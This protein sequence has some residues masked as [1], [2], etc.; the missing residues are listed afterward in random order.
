M[1]LPLMYSCLCICLASIWDSKCLKRNSLHTIALSQHRPG[2]LHFLWLELKYSCQYIQHIMWPVFCKCFK[3]LFHFIWSLAHNAQEIKDLKMNSKQKRQ[4]QTENKRCSLNFSSNIKS[5]C[6]KH[7]RFIGFLQITILRSC[8]GMIQAMY[9]IEMKNC[10]PL[11]LSIPPTAYRVPTVD[12]LGLV[13]GLCIKVLLSGN[14]WY[15]IASRISFWHS[16]SFL[17]NAWFSRSA[18]ICE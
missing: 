15:F 14:K 11:L 6:I 17:N 16:R 3:S 2:I 10:V 9:Y 5:E 4:P 18:N 7:V 8:H 1:Y 13:L 12:F